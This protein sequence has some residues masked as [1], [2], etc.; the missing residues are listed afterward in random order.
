MRSATKHFGIGRHD[1]VSRFEGERP[2]GVAL[3]ALSAVSI[4]NVS[5]ASVAASSFPRAEEEETTALAG[6]LR[7]SKTWAQRELLVD[8]RG[9]VARMLFRVLGPRNDIDDLIHDVF[10]RALECI[11]RLAE[12]QSVAGWLGAIAVFVAREDIRKRRRRKWLS[13]LSFDAIPDRESVE[14]SPE[15]SRA[16]SAVHDVLE[17]LDPD[18]RIVFALRY[19]DERKLEEIAQLVRCSL[20]TVKRRLAKADA[21]FAMRAAD[22]PWLA[23]WFEEGTR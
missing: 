4:P 5:S 7:A 18:E 15:V 16:L 21:T 22:D 10:V 14:G 12:G 1:P 8:Y 23:S 3:V 19:I 6:G 17:T 2:L 9:Y 13:F 11:D 20:A